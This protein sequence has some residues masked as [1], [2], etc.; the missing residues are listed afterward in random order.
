MDFILHKCQLQEHPGSIITQ[1]M[2]IN[3]SIGNLFSFQNLIVFTGSVLSAGGR[4]SSA[5]SA[6]QPLPTIGNCKLEYGGT[7]ILRE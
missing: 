7:E 3:L 2:D 5:E 4:V 1:L 6:C